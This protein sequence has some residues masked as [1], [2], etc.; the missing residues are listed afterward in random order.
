MRNDSWY[1]P[2]ED[3]D[4]EAVSWAVE[5]DTTPTPGAAYYHGWRLVW[6]REEQSARDFVLWQVGRNF[7]EYKHGGHVRI[8][9]CYQADK[10]PNDDAL[11]E[12][13]R[14]V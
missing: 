4:P 1:D 14:H 13:M 5:Y 7:P 12:E 10:V 9:Q 8:R 6:A 3:G 11:A 2:P